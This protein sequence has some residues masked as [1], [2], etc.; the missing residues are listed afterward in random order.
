M[1]QTYPKPPPAGSL[2]P[3]WVRGQTVF[4]GAVGDD[5]STS[6][7]TLVTDVGSGNGP[8]TATDYTP[9]TQV[10]KAAIV[11]MPIAADV[12]RARGSIEPGQRY[13]AAGDTPL[14]APTITSLSPNTAV[15]GPNKPT[16]AV[17]ITGTGFTPWSSVTSGN[18]PIPCRYL[19][20][21]TLEIIQK[22]SASVPGVVSVV[23]T[24]HGV[25]SAGSN[26]TFT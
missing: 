21:T 23:V 1:T 7:A 4:G 15:T 20:A 10:A 24:D 17:T 2:T 11:G 14:A 5:L 18:F 8:N 25:A 26:F 6:T 13:P 19:T 3:A 9:R 12:G 16:V 22:P